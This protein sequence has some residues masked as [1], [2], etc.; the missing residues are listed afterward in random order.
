M[1]QRE[2]TPAPSLG[3]GPA[4][5]WLL[6]LLFPLLAVAK[7]WCGSHAYSVA[8]LPLKPYLTVLG[9][10]PLRFEEP[11]P[12][13]DLTTHPPAS[14]PPLP[15]SEQRDALHHQQ[16]DEASDVV[17]TLPPAT[18]EN[19]VAQVV[20]SSV[21]VPGTVLTPGTESAAVQPPVVRVPPPILPDDTLPPVRAEDF[22]PYF[23]IPAA[24]PGD[25]SVIVPVPRTAPTAAPLP[26]SSATYTQTPR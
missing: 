17:S 14:A 20:V 2:P 7:A 23:Q 10:P 22:L 21:Y 9:A 26:P 1:N 13:P 6:L 19:N 8:V 16:H 18:A 3:A 15:L 11:L 4:L 25:P 5:P 24:H 12:P